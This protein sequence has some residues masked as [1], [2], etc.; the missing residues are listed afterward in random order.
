MSRI[1]EAFRQTNKLRGPHIERS[2]HAVQVVDSSVL[3]AFVRDT[4]TP[5]D[6]IHRQARIPSR[7]PQVRKTAASLTFDRSYD[8]K[9]VVGREIT[10]T[11]V[12]QFRRVAA[13]LHDCQQQHGT[14]TLMVSSAVPRE[15]KTLTASN[16]A[17]TLSESFRRRVLLMDADLRR[18]SIQHVFGFSD[19]RGLGD[20]LA[21]GEGSLPLHEVSPCLSVLTAG[22]PDSSPVAHLASDS[23]RTVIADAAAQFEWVVIDAPPVGA[24]P[25]ARLIA[26]LVDAILFVID[27]ST[28]PYELV[29]RA[30]EELGP[31]RIIGTVL[32]RAA[33]ET[34]PHHYDSYYPGASK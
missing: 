13:S 9:V 19:G 25:D 31:D 18:P 11:C 2:E 33:A 3:D 32:N 8:G 12:E 14:K 34:L 29:Q 17:L 24:L 28:T 16:V 1:D 22:R 27:V 26:N 6:V 21:S 5:V 7:R 10:A 15:G 30:I 4:E 23:M 20:V